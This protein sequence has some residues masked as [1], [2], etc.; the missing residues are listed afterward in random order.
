MARASFNV[1]IRRGTC[2]SSFGGCSPQGAVLSCFFG[3]AEFA[4]A[5][6][7]VQR[8]VHRGDWLVTPASAALSL[9]SESAASSARKSQL[10]PSRTSSWSSSS[11]VRSQR[12]NGSLC[13]P[14]LLPEFR[15]EP[16]ARVSIAALDELDALTNSR[17][18]GIGFGHAGLLKECRD[19]QRVN[20]SNLQD[21]RP[22][23]LIR[24]DWSLE[25]DSGPRPDPT[26]DAQAGTSSPVSLGRILRCRCASNLKRCPVCVRLTGR[27]WRC[28][29]ARSGLIRAAG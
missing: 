4:V 14:D 26:A 19:G 2:S 28:G 3:I 29:G 17:H 27:S 16:A 23:G 8:R 21:D 13:G 22:S 6:V 11:S 1:G 25:C 20:A 15:E 18:H 10:S 24:S 7:E 12:W 9:V 5:D